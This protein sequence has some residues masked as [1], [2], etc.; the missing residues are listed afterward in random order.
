VNVSPFLGYASE[1]GLPS[2]FSLQV[3]AWLNVS[4]APGVIRRK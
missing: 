4:F 3:L 1:C 2:H